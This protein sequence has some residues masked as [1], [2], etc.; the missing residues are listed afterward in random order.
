MRQ[1]PGSA[2]S[3]R[4]RPVDFD[5][6]D[7]QQA[8]RDA[9]AALLDSR[10]APD[11]VR[12]AGNRPDRI[13]RD[14]WAQMA[15]QGWLAVERSE[16]TGGLGMGFVEL[17]VL[18]EQLGSHLAPVPFI[19]TVLAL[20]ALE[21][22]AA[23]EGR[24]G[25]ADPAELAA[26][27]EMVERLSNGEAIGAVAWSRRADQVIA[28]RTGGDGGAGGDGRAGRDGGAGGDGGAGVGW[29]LTGSTD[30]VVFGPV[31]DVVLVPA[32]MP[33]NGAGSESDIALFA[34]ALGAGAAPGVEPGMDLTRCLGRLEL[35]ATPATLLGGAESF[36]QI[37]DRASVA[38]S[39]EMLGAAQHVL[40]M[41]V[42]YAKD[43]VQF[44]RPIGSFQAVKH[45]CAD[46][47]VDVEG[48]R[49]AVYYAA[50]CLAAGSPDATTAAS[51][52]KIWC[53][54]A[55]ARVMASGL[56]VHGGIGFTWEHDLHLFV[57]RSQLDQVS[58]GDAP[59]HRDRLAGM[60]RHL[61]EAG[62][63]VL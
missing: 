62:L 61:A 12:E 35:D 44:G 25:S 4:S 9:A 37:T 63:P 38:V 40:E 22:A 2:R 21:R 49:S 56:Q 43:R 46:M 55:A 32:L 26:V 1:E 5:L 42:Q 18:C 59:W 48:M 28:E 51:A 19:G 13:D 3:V 34:V 33:A 54:E 29:V 11:R 8:L 10:A 20:G 58:F 36:G 14:L 23:A 47:L 50:W 27:A 30:P 53:S 45:R 6:S 60:L 15:E 31:A 16:A 7:D 57:K 39:A 52:A 24:A 41:T 17:A